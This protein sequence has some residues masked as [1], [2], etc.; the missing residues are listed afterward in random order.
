M[1]CVY[2][3]LGQ[4]KILELWNKEVVEKIETALLQM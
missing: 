2:K 1:M 3:V 4:I